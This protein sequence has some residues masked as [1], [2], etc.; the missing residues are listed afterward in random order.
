MQQ[1][2][3]KREHIKTEFEKLFDYP[4]TLAVAAMGYGKTTSA[5][6]FLNDG[7]FRYIWLTVDSD[8]SSPQFIWDAFTSQLS[9]VQ[10]ETGRQLRTFGFPVDAPQRDKILRLIEDL[11]YMTDSVL[12]IDDYHNA[13]TP[14]L[15]RLIE[16][17]VRANIKGFHILIL[18]RTMP[19]LHIDEL[20]LKGYCHLIKSSLF[21]VTAPEIK[22]FFKLYGHNISDQT[23]KQVYDISEGWVSAVYL[24]MQDYAE[25]GRV[26]AGQSME[27]LIEAAVMKRYAPKEVRLLKSLC[28]L[29]NFTPRQAVY[30]TDER[31]AE[32]ILQKIK[33]R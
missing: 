2:I 4:L 23:A 29:D 27:R 32:K 26:S 7:A 6:D 14:E 31:A 16:R 12:V 25:T 10:P 20:L 5:R 17:L 13:H 3:L 22:N 9:K 33:L 8:E 28:I 18:S 1:S 30:V 15:D 19:E 24:M 21:E 11:T